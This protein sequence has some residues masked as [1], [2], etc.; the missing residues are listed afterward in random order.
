MSHLSHTRYLVV[1]RP[2]RQAFISQT[3][4]TMTR[5]HSDNMA[6]KLQTCWPLRIKSSFA[7]LCRPK[8]STRRALVFRRL[9]GPSKNLLAIHHRT[10]STTAVSPAFIQIGGW[11]NSYYYFVFAYNTLRQEALSHRLCRGAVTGTKF[12]VVAK[13]VIQLRLAAL[14]THRVVC[15][16]P[17][18]AVSCSGTLLAHRNLPS[19][20]ETKTPV[21]SKS[22]EG[23]NS[24]AVENLRC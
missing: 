14:G 6:A 12:D 24:H 10:F 19:G 7:K 5:R 8:S 22:T 15:D 16:P 2:A 3:L 17:G 21:G 1:D 20:H 13:L 4:P 11:H 9:K 23:T 18:S